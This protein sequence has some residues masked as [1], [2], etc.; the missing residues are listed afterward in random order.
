MF[1]FEIDNIEA[2]AI[3][4]KSTQYNRDSEYSSYDSDDSEDKKIYSNREYGD[5]YGVFEEVILK[6]NTEIIKLFFF[7]L[8][9]SCYFKESDHKILLSNGIKSDDSLILPCRLRR[10]LN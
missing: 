7:E 5:I 6:G 2:I 10:R 4:I 8:K 9:K 1:P 3:I